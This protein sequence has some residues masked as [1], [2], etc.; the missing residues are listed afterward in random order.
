MK[1]E[2]FTGMKTFTG[3]QGVGELTEPPL[4]GQD[5][6]RVLKEIGY[7]P[8]TIADLRKREIIQ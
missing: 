4:P 1:G 7:D 8:E 5:T 6:E 2:R 3:P